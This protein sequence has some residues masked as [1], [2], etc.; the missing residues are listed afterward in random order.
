[1]ADRPGILFV[2]GCIWIGG[3]Q[4]SIVN[5]MRV[6]E[7]IQ[8]L[9]VSTSLTCARSPGAGL[10]EKQPLQVVSYATEGFH[11]FN[12]EPYART[13][14]HPILESVNVIDFARCPGAGLHE[15]QIVSYATESLIFASG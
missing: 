14:S 5:R 10:R 2:V 12:C 6:H 3:G 8:S 9:S 13:R 7:V 4:I 15:K 11:Y 1:M